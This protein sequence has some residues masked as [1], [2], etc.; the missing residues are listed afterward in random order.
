[1]TGQSLRL[2]LAQ[3]ISCDIS[4]SLSPISFVIC[5]PSRSDNSCP[6][7]KAVSFPQDQHFVA[8]VWLASLD[9]HVVVLVRSLLPTESSQ[10]VGAAST[11]RRISEPGYMGRRQNELARTSGETGSR[12]R[13]NSKT[14]KS[15]ELPA[16]LTGLQT[17]QGTAIY[18][19]PVCYPAS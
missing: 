11:S 12:E 2:T 4:L 10:S 9:G 14:T 8:L 17:C 7:L 3:A 1:M 19:L 18:R 16:R 5:L 15:N 13:G 6:L